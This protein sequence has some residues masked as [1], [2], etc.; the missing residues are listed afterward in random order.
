MKHMGESMKRVILAVLIVF[1]AVSCSGKKETGTASASSGENVT[2]KSS[3]GST[4]TVKAGTPAPAS[5][6]NVELY[7][8]GVIITDYTGNAKNLTIPATIED[9]PVVQVGF[10]SLN[11]NVEQVFI[12][13]GVK[14]VDLRGLYTNKR[15]G[16]PNLRAVSLPNT[17]ESI[18][19]AAF[20]GCINLKSIT[21]PPNVT[22]IGNYAFRGTG[23]QSIVIPAS[24]NKMLEAFK[25]CK[26]LV[27]AEISGNELKLINS[28]SGCDNLKTIIINE[29][30][31]GIWDGFSRLKNLETI[32][33]PDSFEFI[34]ENAFAD[35]PN[36]KAVVIPKGV[37]YI[38]KNAFSNSGLT[39]VTISKTDAL[40]TIY[41]GAFSDCQNLVTINF[42]EGATIEF[43]GGA[44]LN[45]P[46]LSLK[47]QAAIRGR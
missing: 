32:K 1:L 28:F 12:P 34:G 33:L 44:F 31:I 3:G 16:F 38:Q 40:L 26:N 20:D 21:I 35:C 46:K 29:G 2:T 45:C 25:D 18:F 41:A 11:N 4:A 15:A 22:Y 27:S 6:F 13:E 19:E 42:E 23:I 47:S 17:L 24:V 14:G 37:E 30:V 9:L 5:D 7:G 10:N 43:K 8:D 39:E 36:L